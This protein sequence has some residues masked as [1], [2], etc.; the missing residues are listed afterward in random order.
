MFTDDLAF[1]RSKGLHP[2]PYQPH[3]SDLNKFAW[4]FP[5]IALIILSL[6]YVLM[7][8]RAH[9]N[10]YHGP[11]L[12]IFTAL[13]CFRTL[14]LNIPRSEDCDSIDISCVWGL[15]GPWDLE[16]PLCVIE[17]PHSIGQA[18]S[19]LQCH[20]LKGWNDKFQR[21]TNRLIMVTFTGAD[22]LWSDWII[23]APTRA[24]QG[25]TICV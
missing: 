5:S 22:N 8:D 17:I 14:N 24:M 1:Q 16:G 21:R 13:Q 10:T 12:K 20:G 15:P 2:R 9:R 25:S 11:R 6:G 23:W 19:G 18:R 7:T 4:D 3:K